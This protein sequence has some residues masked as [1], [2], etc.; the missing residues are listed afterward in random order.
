MT[1]TRAEPDAFW[2]PGPAFTSA[3]SPQPTIPHRIASIPT[4]GAIITAVMRAVAATF[5]TLGAVTD[6]LDGWAARRLGVS[7]PFGAL[8]DYFCDY[9]CFVRNLPLASLAPERH[10]GIDRRRAAGGQVAGEKRGAD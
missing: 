9:L 2:N 8:F 4:S 3:T 1:A 10:I 6:G 7:S 5:I